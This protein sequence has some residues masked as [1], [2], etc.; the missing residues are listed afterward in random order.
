MNELSRDEIEGF[1]D[2]QTVGRVGCHHAGVT[3]VVPVIYARRVDALYVLTTEGQKIQMMRNNPAVCFEVDEYD[4]KTGNWRS[5]IVQ[6]SYEE[7]DEDGKAVAVSVLSKRFG[8]R[9][10]P[11]RARMPVGPTV[12]FC[13]HIQSATGR[14]VRRDGT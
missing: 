10:A 8:P 14:F 13:I 6:G 12:A 9:R 3:Y 2:D 1:L 11:E 4:G 5:V 7:L